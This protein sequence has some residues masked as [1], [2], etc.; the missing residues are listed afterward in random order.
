M[1]WRRLLSARAWCAAATL[2][3]TFT[4]STARSDDAKPAVASAKP[5]APVV[6]KSD[7]S[8]SA[9]PV[10][11]PVA[12]PFAETETIGV[13]EGQRQGALKVEARGKGRDHVS[14]AVEN[15]T[16]KRLN[17]IFP[18]G[19]VAAMSV[20]QAAGGRAGGGQSMG[21]GSIDNQGNAFGQFRRPG[22][23]AAAAGFRSVGTEP[24]SVAR[25]VVTVPAGKRIELVSSSA[26]LNF[27]LATPTPRDR[28]T[29]MDVNDYSNDP[30]VRKAL[31]SLSTYGTSQGVAQAAL[32]N[33]CN[34]LSFETM[35]QHVGQSFN[36]SEL[37]LAARFVE[38][39]DASNGAELVD[40]TYLT[41]GRLFV[42]VVG[43]GKAASQAARLGKSLD[44]MTILGLRVRALAPNEG[45]SAI[46]PALSLNVTLTT[47]NAGE[48]RG[49]V[50]VNALAINNQQWMP[51][52]RASFRDGSEPSH[53]EAADLA[54]AID[55][56][57]AS[58]LVTVRPYRRGTG[59]TTLRVENKLPFTI[60]TVTIKAAGVNGSAAHALVGLGVGP[61]RAALAPIEASSGAVDRV[62]LNGL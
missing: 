56:A 49:K 21:L 18:P 40:P 42:R 50:A 5:V 13:L 26:C 44:G 53:L 31:R 2:G 47:G 17:V 60:D 25:G 43:E 16:N 29:L 10:A 20:G 6:V 24:V 33:V 8:K 58:A 62:T 9:Q 45:I 39:V 59:V 38:A 14:I 32:W 1:L 12:K 52:G 34:G 41:E 11:A 55:H 36:M 23:D 3:C 48:T 22:G 37:A 35:S 7:A 28:F 19:L 61:G 4:V 51:V 15:T 46:S 30:R 57:V 54:R 27:G